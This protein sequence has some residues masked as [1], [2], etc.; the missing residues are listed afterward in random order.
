LKNL[1]HH[2]HQLNHESPF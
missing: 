1:F 2:C